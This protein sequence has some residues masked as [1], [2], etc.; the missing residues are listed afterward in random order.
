MDW[1][2]SKLYW[3]DVVTR[4]IGVIDLHSRSYT[5]LLT[6]GS[7]ANPRE[8]VVDPTTRYISVK[9]YH[10]MCYYYNS[11]TVCSTGL[12]GVHAQSPE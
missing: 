1:I 3:T 5:M 10:G 8:I 2:N 6:S 11:H 12:N 4:W 9:H 7:D